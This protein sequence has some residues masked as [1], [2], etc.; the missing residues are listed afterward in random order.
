MSVAGPFGCRCPS[1]RPCSVSTSRSSNRTCGFPHPALGQD[2]HAF[3]HG[4]LRVSARQLDQPQCLVQ[5]LVREACLSHCRD[6][7]LVAQPPAEPSVGVSVDRPVALTDRTQAEVVRP[8]LQLPIESRDHDRSASST[9]PFGVGLRADRS[10][11]CAG[12]S[13]STDAAPDRLGP[14][15]RVAPSEGVAQKVEPLLRHSTHMGLLLVHRQLQPRASSAASPPAP[16]RRCRDSRSPESSAYET[17]RASSRSL[18][19]QP[20]PPQHEP[21]H[22]QILQQR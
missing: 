20:L 7:V 17:M 9:V 11:P 2:T 21:P 12:Y 6:L 19:P 14:S 8:A 1:S 16:L 5:V 4:R 15:C 10:R 3:A 18:E 13:S 22:V